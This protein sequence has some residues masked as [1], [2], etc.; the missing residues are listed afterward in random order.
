MKKPWILGYPLSALAKTDQTGQMPRLIWDFAGRT[1]HFVGFVMRRL[2]YSNPFMPSGLF[3][4]CK[5]DKSIFHW[6]GVWCIFLFLFLNRNCVCKL[7]VMACSAASD[8]GLHVSSRSHLWETMGHKWVK[9]EAM[10]PYT[11]QLY[12]IEQTCKS[13]VHYSSD[14]FPAILQVKGYLFKCHI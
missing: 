8:W 12:V 5:L 9:I 1:D 3:Y 11:A 14:L 4:P 7:T 6:R 2:I 10:F 13:D